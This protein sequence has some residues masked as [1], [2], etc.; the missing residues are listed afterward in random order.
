METVANVTPDTQP[1]AVSQPWPCVLCG[2][3]PAAMSHG[4]C[5]WCVQDKLAEQMVL[6]CLRVARIGGGR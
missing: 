3:T 4:L 2:R 6:S 5:A 1:A